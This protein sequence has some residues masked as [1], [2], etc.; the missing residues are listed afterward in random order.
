[1]A[2]HSSRLAELASQHK[3]D[4]SQLR[5][6]HLLDLEFRLILLFY[7]T[8]YRNFWFF[9]KNCILP[10]FPRTTLQRF[11]PVLGC[12]CWL[13][14]PLLRSLRLGSLW[15][16]RLG[17]GLPLRVGVRLRVSV[18]VISVLTPGS[19]FFVCTTTTWSTG[20]R[21]LILSMARLVRWRTSITG[22][23][24][25]FYSTPSPLRCVDFC[26]D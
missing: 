4:W 6:T 22:V 24:C 26:P 18:I 23:W 5:V 15:V 2:D 3:V 13:H 10:W 11:P 19:V 12:L 25:A 17:L 20:V 8:V 21:R 9:F 7:N 1:M 14:S 16:F